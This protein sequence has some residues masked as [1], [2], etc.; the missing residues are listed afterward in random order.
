MKFSLNFLCASIGVASTGR[1][2]LKKK[3]SERGETTSELLLI[4]LCHLEL[5]GF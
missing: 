2:S 5:V 1:T 3:K 4:N